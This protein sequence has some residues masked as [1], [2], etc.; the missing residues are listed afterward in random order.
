LELNT[1][2]IVINATLNLVQTQ[3]QFQQNRADGG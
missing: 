3:S 1:G 2:I